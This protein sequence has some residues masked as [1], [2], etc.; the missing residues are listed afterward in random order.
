MLKT[1]AD[2]KRRPL[3]VFVVQGSPEGPF[4]SRIASA[5]LYRGSCVVS[6]ECK[7]RLEKA[8]LGEI[9]SLRKT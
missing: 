2:Q 3:V 8:I 7:R 9:E 5:A 4:V 6:T 1:V